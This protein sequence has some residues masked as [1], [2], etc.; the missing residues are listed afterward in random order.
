[1]HD[2]REEQTLLIAQ[3][4]RKNLAFIYAQKSDGKDVE[5]FTQLLNSMLGLVI[6]LREDYYKG[7][8]FQWTEMRSLPSYRL[9][10]ENITGNVLS[11]ES[12]NLKQTNSFSQLITKI[13]HSFAHNCYTLLVRN[14][15]ERPSLIL[16]V[17]LWN[18]PPNA[19]NDPKNRTWQADIKEADLKDLALLLLDYLEKEFASTQDGVG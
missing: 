17:R 12:P 6:G 13:R 3:K 16:G 19:E 18:I 9:E 4:T 10:L 2:V 11:P 5:E 8:G 14:N 1:M 7:S 15:E